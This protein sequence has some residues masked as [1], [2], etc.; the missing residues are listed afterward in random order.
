MARPVGVAG[1]G[2]C[3]ASACTQY[4]SYNIRITSNTH[5][6][7]Y[8]DDIPVCPLPFLPYYSMEKNTAIQRRPHGCP[9]AI[10]CKNNPLSLPCHSFPLPFSSFLIYSVPVL[11]WLAVHSFS[12]GSFVACNL[13]YGYILLLLFIFTILFKINILPR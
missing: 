9:H 8:R 7:T 11:L 12:P 1:G 3:P 2:G 10:E 6:N 13:K 5:T 4:Y